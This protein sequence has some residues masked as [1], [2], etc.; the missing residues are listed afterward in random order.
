MDEELA[1]LAWALWD[2]GEIDDQ[3][4]MAV[5]RTLRDSDIYLV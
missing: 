2:K 4:A 1:D 5:W 3:V